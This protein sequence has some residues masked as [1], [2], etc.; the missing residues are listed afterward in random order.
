MSL[1]DPLLQSFQLTINQ[2]LSTFP[3]LTVIFTS[4][5]TFLNIE[6]DLMQKMLIPFL[7]FSTVNGHPKKRQLHDDIS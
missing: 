2:M 1:F 7:Y 5:S 4:T 3:L 6:V